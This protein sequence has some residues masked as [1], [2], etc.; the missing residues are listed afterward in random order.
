MS[1]TGPSKNLGE[2]LDAQ[3]AIK[4]IPDCSLGTN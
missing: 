2:V 1:T 4:M 3:T